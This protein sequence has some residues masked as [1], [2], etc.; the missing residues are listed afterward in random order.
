[1]A[2]QIYNSAYFSIIVQLII[3]FI[4]FYAININLKP[5]DKILNELLILET[6]VQ[7]IEFLFYVF[8]IFSFKKIKLNL[9][10]TR[11]FDWLIT[12]PLML[13]TIISFMIYK[14]TK[15]VINI[16]SILKN[17]VSEISKILLLNCGMLVMGLL[18]ELKKINIPFAFIGGSLLFSASFYLI[19]KNYVNNDIVN[20]YIFWFNFVIWSFYGIS[21]LLSYKN[22]NIAY[23]FLDILSKN[24]NALMLVFYINLYL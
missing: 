20:Q 17:N 13:F 5:K 3:I 24:I 12:T 23:N 19:Y 22:K 10:I 4:S 9:S 16:S 8:L 15:N 18:G 14:N 21:Y 2:K 6:I 11:Y 1:M 7:I